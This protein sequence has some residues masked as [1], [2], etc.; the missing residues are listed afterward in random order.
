MPPSFR[1]TYTYDD[2]NLKPPLPGVDLIMQVGLVH[3]RPGIGPATGGQY[4][5]IPRAVG[6]RHTRLWRPH[7]KV[8]MTLPNTDLQLWDTPFIVAAHA[9]GVYSLAE[10]PGWNWLR[11]TIADHVEHDLR[12]SS[13]PEH[14]VTPIHPAPSS[15]PLVICPCGSVKAAQPRPAGEMYLGGY[16][17]LTL[18]AAR[19]LTTDASIRIIS[20]RHG[21]LSL[22]RIIDPYELRLGQPGSIS[23]ELLAA[24]AQD[25]GIVD[26]PDVIVLGGRDYTNLARQVWPSARTPLAGTRGIGEQQHRLAR[27]AA[28]GHLD[29]LAS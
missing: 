25:Q 2:A 1:P 15:R 16:H 13:D 22:D 17:R 23:A 19:A 5:G 29:V 12:R 24:Q 4:I 10:R 26:H 3:S 8:E 20:A 14:G 11:W 21:L 27:I 9:Q 28:I 6:P 7:D 18:R